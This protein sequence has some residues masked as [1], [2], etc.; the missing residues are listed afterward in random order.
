MGALETMG[1]EELKRRWEAARALLHEHGVSYDAYGDPQGVARPW[2]LSPLPVVVGAETWSTIASGLAQRARVLDRILA[3]LYGPRRL[4]AAGDLPPELVYAH[5]GFLRP[6]AG[7]VPAAGH[8]LPLYAADLV[9]RHDGQVA[10]L[11]DRTQ[12]PSGIGFAL[13]NRIILSRSLPEVFRDCRV[14]RLATF[15]RTL[16]DTLR[17]LAP[18]NRDNPRIVLLTPGPYNATYFEQAFLAQYLDLTLARGDDLVVRDRRLYLKTLGGLRPID[19][20][21]RRV[22]DGFW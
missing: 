19:V 5:P 18:H 6:C 2:N 3:D 15:F 8:Y 20:V 14:V 12:A 16:R 4:V 21:L 9:R 17:K 1:R 10:V 13:E 22:N 7:V 11:A